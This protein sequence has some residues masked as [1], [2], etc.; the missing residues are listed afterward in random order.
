MINHHQPLLVVNHLF[1]TH[2]LTIVTYWCVLRRVA[3]WV[4]GGC[5]DDDITYYY[6]SDYGSFPKIPCVRTSKLVHGNDSTEFR[7]ECLS[8]ISVEVI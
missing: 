6:Y 8:M 7:S 5:W 4:A 2:L 1:I 3:G